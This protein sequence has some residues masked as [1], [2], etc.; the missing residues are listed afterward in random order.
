MFKKIVEYSF[1]N[2]FTIEFWTFILIYI[3]IN[4]INQS[5]FISF[6]DIIICQILTA[7]IFFFHP[8]SMKLRIK[9]IKP[10]IAHD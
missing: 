10:H 1:R 5:P 3:G 9:I 6:P 8:F 7:I 4:T 2:K